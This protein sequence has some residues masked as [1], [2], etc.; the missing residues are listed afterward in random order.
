MSETIGVWGE[1]Y[2][3]GVLYCGPRDKWAWSPVDYLSSA[4]GA[5]VQW[6]VAQHPWDPWPLKQALVF[7]PPQPAKPAPRKKPA[8]RRGAH[9]R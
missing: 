2:G 3:A 5:V 1:S 9:A 8:A 4:L 7:P 6:E